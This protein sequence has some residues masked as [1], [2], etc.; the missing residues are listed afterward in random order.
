MQL[1]DAFLMPIPGQASDHLWFV[2]SDPAQHGGTFIIANVTT[3]YYRAGKECPLSSFDHPWIKVDCFM[4]FSDALE[5]TPQHAA[6]LDALL[7]KYV[8]MLAPLTT[9]SLKKI[10]ASAKIS[11]AIPVRYKKFL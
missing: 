5:I 10:V 8:T 3:D 4:N 1:G 11:K 7:G 9:V 2:I 6:R